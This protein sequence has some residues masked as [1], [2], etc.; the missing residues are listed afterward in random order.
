MA[1]A[2]FYPSRRKSA[3]RGSAGAPAL[4]DGHLLADAGLKA[5]TSKLMSADSFPSIAAPFQH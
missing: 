2:D 1:A 5:V 4:N 3:P